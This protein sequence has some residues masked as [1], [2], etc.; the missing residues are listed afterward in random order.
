[1]LNATRDA[2]N[3]L[4]GGLEFD[5]ED[6]Q[7]A[8]EVLLDRQ[9][10][11]GSFDAAERSA[12]RARMLS[13]SLAEGLTRLIKDTRR[14]IRPVL[15]EWATD[16]PKRLEEAREHIRLRLEAEHRLQV[17]VQDSL[18]SDDPGVASSAGRIAA[19][20]REC[21]ARH[22]SLHKQV[23]AARGVF[24]EE[25]DRQSFRPPAYTYLPDLT[26]EVL[27]PLLNLGAEDVLDLT[28]WF[29]TDVGGPRAP[30]LP[31]LGSLL[32]DLWAIREMPEPDDGPDDADELGDAEALLVGPAI[33]EAARR[34][35][36]ATGLPARLSAL[37]A[38][39]L[40]DPDT[41]PAD[42]QPAAEV[43]ALTVLWSFPTETADDEEAET[44]GGGEMAAYVLGE[45]AAADT[46]E[47][48]LRLPGWDGDDLIVVPH[49]DAFATAH[50]TP[51]TRLP[52]P[53]GAA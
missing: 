50:P 16:V 49:A 6:E 13:V 36:V 30:R 20:L 40:T 10:T 4:I 18:E 9:L 11:R 31:R 23:I 17:K 14:D 42:R 24:L 52:A 46:D 43:L 21:Q 37:L 8:N 53:E 29:F 41:D 45:R 51:V 28:G 39:C 2:I 48:P 5:V 3:A 26:T 12:A 32:D 47:T 1:V 34:A 27:D 25:Q 44:A 15:E 22:E 33:V 7:V 19:L 35:V 38:A